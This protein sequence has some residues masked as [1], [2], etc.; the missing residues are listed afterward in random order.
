MPKSR[1]RKKHKEKKA[2]Y[3]N[4]IKTAKALHQHRMNKYM[5][6]L[7]ENMKNQQEEAKKDNEI[8]EVKIIEETHEQE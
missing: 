1:N 6:M 5:Q 7:M 2:A 3:K 8:E 4:T